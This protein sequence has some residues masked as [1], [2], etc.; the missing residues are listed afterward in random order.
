MFTAC[1]IMHRRCCLLVPRLLSAV[2]VTSRHDLIR[3][4]VT[5]LLSLSGYDILSKG[6]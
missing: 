1:V 5:E 6:S 2:R 3:G 4:I